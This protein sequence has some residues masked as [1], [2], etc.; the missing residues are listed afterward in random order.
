MA[1]RWDDRAFKRQLTGQLVANGEIVGKFVEGEAKQRLLAITDPDWG[2]QYRG[3]VARLITSEVTTERR[4]VVIRVGVRRSYTKW[5]GYYIELGTSRR[6]AH[7]YLRPSVFQNG[8]KIVA[9]LSGG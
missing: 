5:H 6:A 1:V 3:Y 2:T 4:A 7:P 8:A 9:L